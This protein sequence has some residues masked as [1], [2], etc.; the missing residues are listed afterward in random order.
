MEPYRRPLYNSINNQTCYFNHTSSR[1][2]SHITP[3][4][5]RRQQQAWVEEFKELKLVKSQSKCHPF[6]VCNGTGVDFQNFN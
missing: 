5:T 1:P 2:T 4:H 3:L 6:W